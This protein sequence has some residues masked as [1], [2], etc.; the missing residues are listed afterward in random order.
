M[1]SFKIF[2]LWFLIAVLP[3]HAAA[4]TMGMSCGPVHQKAM[5]MALMDHAHHGDVATHTHHH[6][7]ANEMSLLADDSS[8]TGDTSSDTSHQHSTC[9]SCTAS[10]IGAAGPPSAFHPTP[11]FSAEEMAAVS[12]TLPTA[13]T[14]PS[15]LE[16]PPRHTFT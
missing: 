16:R 5:R 11:A 6:H 9:S 8:M 15:G 1:K 13:D 7:D 4:A 3:L 12:P 14:I 10:C 2:L